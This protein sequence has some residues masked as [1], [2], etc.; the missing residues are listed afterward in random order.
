MNCANCIFYDNDTLLFRMCRL[1]H[2]RLKNRVNHCK[3]NADRIK[4][5]CEQLGVENEEAALFERIRKA[6]TRRKAA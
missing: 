4:I 3:Y 2:K 6:H 5:L 1:K